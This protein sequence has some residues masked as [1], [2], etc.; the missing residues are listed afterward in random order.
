MKTN[1]I[2]LFLLVFNLATLT[3]S[4]LPWNDEIYFA[5]LSLSLAQQNSLI[6]TILPMD[7]PPFVYLY[8]P[9]YF[10]IQASLIKL[11]GLK[12]L[13]FRSVNFISSIGILWILYRYFRVNKLLILL[14]AVSPLFIQNAH[15]GRMDLLATFFALAGYIPF[16]DQMKINWQRIFLT[17]SFFLLAF[18]TSP[19]VGFLFPGLYVLLSSDFRVTVKNF[20]LI[21]IPPIIVVLGLIGW[22]LST[23]GSLLEAYLPIFKSNTGQSSDAHIGISFI[24]GHLDDLLSIV[25]LIFGVVQL[26]KWY[27]SLILAMLMNFIFFSIFVKEVGPYGAMVMP[28][29]ILGLSRIDFSN[30]YFKSSIKLILIIFSIYFIGKGTFLI[31][32]SSSRNYDYV[33]NFIKSNIPPGE[34][35]CATN[36]Y[37]YSLLNNNNKPLMIQ[38]ES[39]EA[40]LFILKENPTYILLNRQFYKSEK[41]NY[42]FG[43]LKYKKIGEINNKSLEGFKLLNKYNI[44][45]GIDGVLLKI[46][47]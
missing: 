36:E 34:K 29:I 23:T 19:R 13:L 11:F 7:N 30:I 39:K 35:V 5:D 32:S 45:S 10:Y 6:N 33:D 17:A 47:N 15:S 2:L 37:Y 18:L 3:I 42:L 28:F 21:L 24:R 43:K 38:F 26:K 9:I 25:F 22:S 1:F 44:I 20:F 16:E 14:L 4:P 31:Y 8:G 40:R 12:I 46:Y 27:N 41:F